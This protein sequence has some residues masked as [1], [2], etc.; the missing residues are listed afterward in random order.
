MWFGWALTITDWDWL[1]NFAL[2]VSLIGLNYSLHIGLRSA[3]FMFILEQRLRHVER[4][5]SW[6]WRKSKRDGG[7][8]CFS[9]AQIWD[10]RTVTWTQFHWP[11]PVRWLSPNSKDN[12]IYSTFSGNDCRISWPRAQNRGRSKKLELKIQSIESI[13]CIQYY[14]KSFPCIVHCSH[15]PWHVYKINFL[16]LFPHKET[17]VEGFSITS[18]SCLGFQ[19]RS[20]HSAS[21][22][23]SNSTPQIKFLPKLCNCSALHK[24]ILLTEENQRQKQE[25]CHFTFEKLLS[26][27]P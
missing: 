6:W 14:A 2:L 10:W 22:C 24:Y 1:E 25:L 16:V 27:T 23:F 9:Y 18:S 7:N 4:C 5:C 26:T 15:F 12:E 17:E 19:T 11:K 20:S 13:H 21:L 8:V 3:L